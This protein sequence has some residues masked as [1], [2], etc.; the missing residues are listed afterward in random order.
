MSTHTK[1]TILFTVWALATLALGLV[2]AIRS[3]ELRD[4]WRQEGKFKQDKE[5]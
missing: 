4:W 1:I 5:Q 2:M 3:G